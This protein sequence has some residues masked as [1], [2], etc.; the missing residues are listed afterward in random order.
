MEKSK[1]YNS[2]QDLA[3]LEHF[4]KVGEETRMEEFNEALKGCTLGYET[5]IDEIPIVQLDID[6]IEGIDAYPWCDPDFEFQMVL[7]TPIIIGR[8]KNVLAGSYQYKKIKEYGGDKI[9]AIYIDSLWGKILSTENLIKQFGNTNVCY[10]FA[11]SLYALVFE[12]DHKIAYEDFCY[13][14][15]FLWNSKLVWSRIHNYLEELNMSM[16]Y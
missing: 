12:R 5:Q 11:Y 6:E 9:S 10:N 16:E 7:E 4:I 14:F 1:V 8:K 13:W 2:K 15:Q 3:R